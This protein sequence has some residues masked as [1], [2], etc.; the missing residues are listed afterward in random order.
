VSGSEVPVRRA[1]HEPARL[2]IFLA[3]FPPPEAQVV[4]A[5]RIARLR[6]SGDGVSWVK[7]AN[8]HYTVRFLG[9]L[10]EDGARRAAEAAVEAAFDHQVFE[11]ELGSVGAFPR[12]GRARVLWLG[13]SRGAGALTALARSVEAALE[14]R[15]FGRADRPF[16]P[17]LTVGRVRDREQDWTAALEQMNHAAAAAGEGA[18]FRVERV[19]VVHSRLSPQGSIYAVRAEGALAG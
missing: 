5:A 18:S 2:R 7:E 11:A 4:A 10:G 19:S 8:L 6:R 14:R 1:R 13:L 17:H 12:A 9:D 3:V 16:A 15:G